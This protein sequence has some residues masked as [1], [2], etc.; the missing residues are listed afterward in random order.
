MIPQQPLPHVSGGA[1]CP[2]CSAVPR[3]S[4]GTHTA[5]IA[6]LA[7]AYC[8]LGENQGCA[9]WCVLVLKDHAEHLAELPISRQEALWR[10]V[11]R[12]AA[13]QRKVFGPVRINY[14]CLGNVVPHIHWHVIPRHADDPE[15]KAP[16]WGWT[17]ERLKGAASPEE[18]ALLIKRLREALEAP[19]MQ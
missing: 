2:L 3:C 15:P 1:G 4:D 13:A 19:K 7:E 12:V 8:I 5:V 9:G 6:E 18:R 14:E 10:D 16:V 17:P 11:A